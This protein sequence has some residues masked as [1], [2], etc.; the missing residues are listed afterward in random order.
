MA[1]TQPSTTA[2]DRNAEPAGLSPRIGR[3]QLR[4]LQLLDQIERL[5]S[6]SAAAA[7]IGVSQPRATNM[8]KEMESA[9]G[10]PLLERSSRGARINAAGSIALERLR[11]ALGAVDAAQ[12]AL[13]NGRQRQLVRIGVLPVVG[14]DRISRAIG[15]LE[16][17]D[18][19]PR[20]LLRV[21]IV[22][23]LLALL[24]AGEVDCIICGLDAGHPA[25][26]ASER[27]RTFSLWE[28]GLMVV[29]A[30]GNPIVRKRKISLEAL[31]QQPWLLMTR[32]SANRQALERMFLQAGLKPPE[33]EVE[34]ESPHIALAVVA[35][36]S[37]IALVPES[38]YRQAADRVS[39][40]RL[41]FRFQPTRVNLITLRDVPTLP[42]VEQLAQRLRNA[43]R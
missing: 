30:K 6:L 28:E 1:S 27:L 20:L 14:I 17:D 34:T 36:S 13:R 8:L 23:E 9:L 19:L 42:V 37:M 38:A 40:L 18:T 10:C 21:G 15:E 43:S 5:G 29:A 2:T 11:I 22:G 3:L 32:K 7:A 16:A 12:L 4:H 25:S 31:L 35:T 41:D 33:P 26:S 24:E 39:P